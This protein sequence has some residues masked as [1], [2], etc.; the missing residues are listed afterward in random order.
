MKP[1]SNSFSKVSQEKQ[2]IQIM[3]YLDFLSSKVELNIK[4]NYK[5]I[6]QLEEFKESQKK[7]F[8]E[9]NQ[10]LQQI[11]VSNVGKFPTPS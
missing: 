5:V 8:D 4:L 7:Q 9:M 10:L 11:N 1:R 2:L 6:K 3:N